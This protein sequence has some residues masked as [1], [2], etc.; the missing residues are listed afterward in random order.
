MVRK[1]EAAQ[2]ILLAVGLLVHTACGARSGLLVAEHAAPPGPTL[3]AGAQ[4]TCAVTPAG[5]AKCWGA[6]D[7]GQLGDGSTAESSVPVEVSG[8]SSGVQ[9][10][11]AGNEHTCAVT[12]AGGVKCW[13]SNS[14]GQL[15]DN[16]TT[17]SAVPVDVAGLTEGALAVSAGGDVTCALTSQGSVQC[18]GSNGYGV[19]G[20]G[21]EID[22]PA[23]A[24][25]VGLEADIVAI[26]A[27]G[28]AACA[29]SNGAS[30]ACWG[31]NEWGQTGQSGELNSLGPNTFTRSPVA[32]TGL[33]G[34]AVD[35]SVGGKQVC[36]LEAAGGVQC[37]GGND[38]GQLGNG[39]D[40]GSYVPVAVMGLS[41]G[42]ATVATGYDDTCA[43]TTSGKLRCWGE[44]AHGQLGNGTI[45]PN[46]STVPVEV[47]G[48]P[49][50]SKAL[51]AGLF[52]ACAMAEATARCWGA[53][54]H[55]QLGDGTT[56]DSSVPVA[57][58]GL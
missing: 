54:D 50:G 52:H 53:N 41:S 58:V 25:V 51:S 40:V 7:S 57:V 34:G 18:W 13:G 48:V 1:R 9:S 14:H 39:S 55:G 36:V 5:R 31:W 44:D 33:S 26:A 23:P 42:A 20:D 15:G 24:D 56:M 28:Y 30:V 16:T 10:I 38:W 29:V 22:R 32:I 46:G 3:S 37:W 45:D 4:H 47:T 17:N 11:S 43:L 49:P 2:R 12:T 35:I 6:N 27:G 21:T 8:L 19:I